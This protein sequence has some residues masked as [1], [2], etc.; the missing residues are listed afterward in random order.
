MKIRAGFVSNSSSSSFMIVGKKLSYDEIT[1]EMIE[2]KKLIA[3]GPE[4]VEGSD[5][6]QIK[7]IE[8][9]AFLKALDNLY[10]GDDRKT[11]QI[12]EVFAYG[13]EDD[14]S[15]EFDAAILPTDGKLHAY[16]GYADYGASGDLS[17]LKNRYDEYGEVTKVMQRYLRAKKINKINKK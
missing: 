5:V 7:T 4:I 1:M 2:N 13:G 15:V 16:N 11:F 14:E 8:Q 6:F 12:L 17:E 9:F 10:H 3:L